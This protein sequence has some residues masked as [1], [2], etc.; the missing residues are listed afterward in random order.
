[1][2]LQSKQWPGNIRE[3]KSVLQRSVILSG[4][5]E[6]LRPED[7]QFEGTNENESQEALPEPHEGFDL[8]QHLS[9]TRSRYIQQAMELA[10]H[11]QSKAAK[12]LGISPQAISNFLKGKTAQ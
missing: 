12:L 8:T 9:E 4:E 1:V 11:N 10:G 3:L 5:K 7:L 6:V 2:A